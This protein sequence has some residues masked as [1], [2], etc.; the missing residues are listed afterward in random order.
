MGFAGVLLPN[1]PG[2][3]PHWF[4]ARACIFTGKF[5]ESIIFY[6]VSLFHFFFFC[7]TST[8]LV[9]YQKK[10]FYNVS[11]YLDFGKL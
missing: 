5:T 11:H 1:V 9:T 6:N 4:L 2:I 10:N 3:G 8:M 7:C